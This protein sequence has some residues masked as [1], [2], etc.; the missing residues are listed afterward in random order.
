MLIGLANEIGALDFFL[1]LLVPNCLAM[2]IILY[3]STVV[4]LHV[5]FSKQQ[6]KYVSHSAQVLPTELSYT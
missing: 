1:E 3:T 4:P 5:G 2:F 6:N